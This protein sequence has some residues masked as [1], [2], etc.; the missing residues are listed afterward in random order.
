LKYLL[1]IPHNRV[2]QS[3][4]DRKILAYLRNEAPVT[5]QMVAE[6]IGVAWNTAQVHL[7]KLMALREVRGKRVGRQNVWMIESNPGGRK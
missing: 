4:L 5:T 3:T 7:Y 2:S 6:A 1:M